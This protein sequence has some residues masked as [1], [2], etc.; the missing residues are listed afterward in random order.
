MFVLQGATSCFSNINLIAILVG[1]KYEVTMARV[2]QGK[3][4]VCRRFTVTNKIGKNLNYV[5]VFSST[6][7]PFV[8]NPKFFWGN[9]M[10]NFGQISHCLCVW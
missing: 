3:I 5:P 1:K 2:E 9:Y 8:S 6:A 10:M 7:F 4:E